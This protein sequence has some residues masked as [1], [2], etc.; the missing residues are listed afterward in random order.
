MA[1]ELFKY[2]LGVAAAGLTADALSKA[3]VVN[4][5]QP[6]TI[7]NAL[8]RFADPEYTVIVQ[9]PVGEKGPQPMVTNKHGDWIV[10]PYGTIQNPLAC[11]QGQSCVGQK[12]Q[13]LGIQEALNYVANKG[14]GKVFIR[15]STYQLSAPV[16]IP[17]NVMIESEHATIAPAPNFSNPLSPY[18]SLTMPNGY[19]KNVIIKSLDF[20]L[21]SATK[22][23]FAFD[24]SNIPPGQNGR[25]YENIILED[26]VFNLGQYGAG[27][28]AERTAVGTLPSRNMIFKNIIA[29]NGGGT[30]FLYTYGS[31]GLYNVKFQNILNVVSV[32]GITDDRV[33]IS[34]TNGGNSSAPYCDCFNIEFDSIY[35]YIEPGVSALDVNGVKIDMGANYAYAHDIAIR[36]IYFYSAPSSQQQGVAIAIY[37]ASQGYVYNYVVENVQVYNSSLHLSLMPTDKSGSVIV[38]NVKLFNNAAFYF[39]WFW[40]GIILRSQNG[41]GKAL[42]SN[43]VLVNR[44]TN[45]RAPFPVG[46]L[47]YSTASSPNVEIYVNSSVIDGWYYAVSN[48][49]QIP[50]GNTV[51]PIGPVYI[52]QSRITNNTN[53]ASGTGIVF[54]DV[55]LVNGLSASLPA[56]PPALGTVYQNTNYSDI[57]IYLPVTFQPTSSAAASVTVS[58]GPSSTSLTSLGTWTVP[59]GGPSITDIVRFK[60]PAGWYYKVSGSNVSL[61]TA[62]VLAVD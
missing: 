43:S 35:T 20:D 45:V 24:D 29:Y 61:G 58:V 7:L 52:R 37:D 62:T 50:N 41:M 53:V 3:M 34:C 48:N 8:Q 6:T 4:K 49:I 30:V 54:K 13:T 18:N 51:T 36:N 14:G 28:I 57:E 11:A 60:V 40:G 59:A 19:I 23:Q 10:D 39:N 16:F 31:S 56:N 55:A 17:S 47:A 21:T 9:P 32:N 33:G 1:E 42:I 26:I 15:R 27:F 25:A 46:L 5:Q 38:D 12:T 44:Y 22:P 2:L